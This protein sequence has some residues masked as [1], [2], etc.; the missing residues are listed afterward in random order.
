[1]FSLG[2]VLLLAGVLALAILWRLSMGPISLG[3]MSGPV[4]QIVNAGLSG[5]RVEFSDVVIEREG[6]NGPPTVRFRHVRLVDEGNR[7]IARAPRATVEIDGAK[8]LRGRVVPRQFDLIGPH[9]LVRRTLSG[10]IELGFGEPSSPPDTA[11]ISGKADKDI[12]AETAQGSA[13]L[14]SGQGMMAFL[15]REMLARDRGGAAAL[16][17]ITVSDASVSLY[18]ETNQSIWYA[19]KVNLD[20]GRTPDGLTLDADA[21][22]AS[23][24]DSWRLDLRAAYRGDTQT[25]SVTARVHDFVPAYAAAQVFAL[26]ELGEVRLPLSGEAHLDLAE[27]GSITRADAVFTASA[28]YVGFPSFISKPILVDEGTLRLSYEPETRE[29]VIGKSAIYIG[30]S[31]AALTGRLSPDYGETGRLLGTRVALHARDVSLDTDGEVTGALAI[32]RVDFEGY[33]SVED[34]RLDVDDLVILAGNAGIR[35]RGSFSEGEEAIGIRLAGRIRDLPIDTMK[36]LWPPI[37]APGAREW[38]SE[39]VLTG[40]IPTGEFTVDMPPKILA[41]ALNDKA[42]P[43]R[44]ANFDFTLSDVTTRYFDD[45]P[46]IIGAAGGGTL[47]GNSFDL[48]LKSGSVTVPSGKQIE[49]VSGDMRIDDLVTHG[50]MAEVNVTTKGPVS[51]FLELID[52]E[53]LRYVSEAGFDM[54]RLTGAAEV[55]M[56]LQLPLLRDIPAERLSVKAKTTI[57]EVNFTGIADDMEIDGGTVEVE[58]TDEGLTGAGDVTLNGVPV[59]L[60]LSSS[61]KDDGPDERRVVARATL[62][63]KDRVRLGTDINDFVKGP[64]PVTLTADISKGDVESAHLTADLS[65]AQLR[66]EAIRWLRPPIKGTKATLDLDFRKDGAIGIRNAAITGKDLNVRGTMVLNKAG[67]IVSASL[68]TAQLGPDYDMTVKASRRSG[69]VLGVSVGGRSFDA[70]P[71]IHAL[72]GKSDKAEDNLGTVALDASLSTVRGYRGS[73]LDR[74]SASAEIR[75][76]GIVRME[77]NGQHSDGSPVALSVRPKTS[78]TR[79]LKLT[80]RNGGA[81]LRAADLY[82]N[83]RDG[84]LSF[85]ADLG[86]PGQSALRDGRLRIRNFQVRDEPALIR[87]DEQGGAQRTRP[88]SG[89]WSFTNLTVPFSVDGQYV[90][91]GDA[92]LQ[93][94]TIGASA[95]GLIN[96]DNGALDISGTIIP[97]YALNSLLS[98][99]PI[100][101]EVLMGGKGQGIFGVTFA[102][103]GTMS[104]PEMVFNPVSALAPGFL[105]KLFEFGTGDG[106]ASGSGS[107]RDGGKRKEP[108]IDMPRAL[109]R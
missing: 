109:N 7:L 97:A 28:G 20:F 10:G 101:G 91:I 96:K 43:D 23:G 105:R 41:Q 5:M 98:S 83:I 34:N 106:G 99:V 86:A 26:S 19:P 79:A 29:I 40:V 48:S 51:G 11:D 75:N 30:G 39:N 108:E 12:S 107:G 1:M 74:V 78:G 2:G 44:H 87:F 27:D 35:M 62:S 94:P 63:D 72:F 36:K 90:R 103:R 60:E 46:V 77:M 6:G 50:T 49:F 66:I 104:D 56:A 3:F 102:L 73:R 95:K 69:N 21:E 37:L 82:S 92:L 15:E 54:D 8:L 71:M 18:D 85:T 45:F 13:F 33:A 59:R 53:P 17:A 47:Q 58:V 57:K 61:F 80:S 14:E 31:Q 16:N 38:I 70:R 89:S 100:L 22:V 65:R 32:D 52:L 24:K 9:I 88:N 42:I 84:N 67:D 93:G 81:T 68:P 64:V 4:E 55:S 25:M 76:G